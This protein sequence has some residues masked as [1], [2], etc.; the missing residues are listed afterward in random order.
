MALLGGFRGWKVIS[1]YGRGR[2]GVKHGQVVVKSSVSVTEYLNMRTSG[3]LDQEL[4][5]FL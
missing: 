5:A 4:V 3:I 2:G 1:I